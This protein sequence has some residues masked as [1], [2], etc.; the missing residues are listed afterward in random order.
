[1]EEDIIK[2]L[3]TS[4][5]CSGCGQCYET[6]NIEVIGNHEDMWFLIAFCLSCRNQ[7]LV[8]LVIEEGKEPEVITDLTEAE[9]AKFKSRGKITDDEI[10]DMHGF[11]K[12]FDGDFSR[13]FSCEKA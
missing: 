6:D 4:I 2:K 11:L 12:G 7:Y 1:M 13:I 8:A 9:L 10:L 3:L 5:K